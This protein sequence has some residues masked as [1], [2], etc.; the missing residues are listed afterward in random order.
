VL[1]PGNLVEID[2]RARAEAQLPFA[3][4]ELVQSRGPWLAEPLPAAAIAWATALTTAALPERHAYPSL[5]SALSALL[6]AICHAPSAR[7][8]VPGLIAYETLLLR[9]MGYGAAM[10]QQ[11]A[12]WAATL[13]AFDGLTSQ[14]ASYGL[15][16]RDRDVM[17]TRAVLR[18]RLARIG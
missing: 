4:A 3:R 2:L 17:G 18:D 6:D 13:A 1:I 9:E 11:G 10:P 5:Y 15:A 12:D 8:W 16:E 7:G 14:L